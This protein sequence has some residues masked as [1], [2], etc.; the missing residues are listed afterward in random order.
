MQ[1][2]EPAKLRCPVDLVIWHFVCAAHV[3]SPRL[4]RAV[5]KGCLNTVNTTWVKSSDTSMT[6]P[7]VTWKRCLASAS[8]FLDSKS[9]GLEKEHTRSTH[10]YTTQRTSM[11]ARTRVKAR[12]LR[13]GLDAL[14]ALIRDASLSTHDIS[15][16]FSSF[17]RK[18]QRIA[19]RATSSI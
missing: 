16:L 6:P 12:M 3:V 14:I 4:R 17:Q 15:R 5:P 10:E 2:L 1:L 9:P 8:L 13:E 18:N 7:S 11:S 19:T